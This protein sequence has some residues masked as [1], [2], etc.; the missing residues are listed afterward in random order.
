R[1]RAGGWA[2]SAAGALVVLLAACFGLGRARAAGAGL[3][4]VIA[5]IGAAIVGSL[6]PLGASDELALGSL[7]AVVAMVA[8][9]VERTRRGATSKAPLV[10]LAIASGLAFATFFHFGVGQFPDAR[11]GTRTRIHY[12]DLRNYFPTAKY[13][14]ELGYEGVYRA[15]VL[16]WV[17]AAAHGDLDAAR[18]VTYRDLD[19]HRMT[20]AAVDRAGLEALRAKLSEPRFEALLVDME[21]FRAIMG[22]ELYAGSMIDHGGNA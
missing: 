20:S 5:A 15:S 12:A 4:V 7:A 3:G 19:T 8:L 18:H 21:Y 2:A 9:L 16:T 6:G 13:F 11:D 22:D 1:L 10:A 14:H 17:A